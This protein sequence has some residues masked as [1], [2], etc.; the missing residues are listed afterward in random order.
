M[1]ITVYFQYRNDTLNGSSVTREEETE[2]LRR[3]I[4]LTSVRLPT[5][6]IVTPKLHIKK[7]LFVKKVHV[8]SPVNKY[9]PNDV[10]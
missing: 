8:K 7:L 6:H 4:F 2:F 5:H 3:K 9:Q 1:I 10:G